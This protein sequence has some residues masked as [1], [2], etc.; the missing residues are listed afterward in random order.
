MKLHGIQ[1]VYG[2]HGFHILKIHVFKNMKKARHSVA[3]M[4]DK[5]SGVLFSDTI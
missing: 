2:I 3:S 5:L 4:I 1:A